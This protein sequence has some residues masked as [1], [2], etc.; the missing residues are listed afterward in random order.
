VVLKSANLTAT[1]DVNDL[2]DVRQED[3]DSHHHHHHHPHPQH[4]YY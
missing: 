1:A 3:N 2:T 4:S